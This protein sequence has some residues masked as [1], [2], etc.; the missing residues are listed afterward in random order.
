LW[1]SEDPRYGGTGTE[2]PDGPTGWRIPGNAAV[3][4][5]PVEQEN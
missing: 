2:T 4:L 1:S 3:A 5:G